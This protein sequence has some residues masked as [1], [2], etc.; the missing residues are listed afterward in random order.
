MLV[1]QYQ[2]LSGEKPFERWLA[3]QD[4][5]A[6][7]RIVA[8]IDRLRAGLRGD[9]KSVGEGVLEL[10]FDFGPG[11][12]VYCGQHGEALVLLLTAGIK[13]TQKKDIEIAHGY[14]KDYL[15]RQLPAQSK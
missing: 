8:R 2:S 13:R 14:W 6:Q 15:Q 5:S 7:V 1:E 9:W 4:R 10:R 11:Y 3:S 12:R